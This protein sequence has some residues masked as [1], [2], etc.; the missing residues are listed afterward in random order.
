MNTRSFFSVHNYMK[1]FTSDQITRVHGRVRVDENSQVFEDSNAL[2]SFI[3]KENNLFESHSK[4]WESR[5]QYY[6]DRVNE[7]RD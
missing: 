4:K 7:R 3:N 2:E 5:M 6:M 1:T